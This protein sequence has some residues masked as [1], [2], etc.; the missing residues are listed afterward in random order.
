M[1][2]IRICRR[3]PGLVVCCGFLFTRFFSRDSVFHGGEIQRLDVVPVRRAY[4]S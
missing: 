4:S 3:Q 1:L 2:R